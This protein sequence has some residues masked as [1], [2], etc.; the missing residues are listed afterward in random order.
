MWEYKIVAYIE[1]ESRID[2]Q[3][4]GREDMEV[5]IKEYVV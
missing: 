1:T 4:Q 3:R 2:C 5:L